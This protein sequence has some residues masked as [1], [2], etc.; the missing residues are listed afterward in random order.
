MQKARTGAA[1]EHRVRTI[2]QQKHLLQLVQCP[3]D[4]TRAGE[5]SVIGPLVLLRAA[6][7]LDLRKGMFLGDED[8][9]KGLV[10]AQQH[11]IARLQLL[12]EV[13]FKQKRLCFRPRRQEHHRRGL[14]DHPRN[15]PRMPRGPGIVRHPRLEVPRLADVKHT[16]LRIQHPVHP[17]RAVKRLEVGLDQA[18]PGRRI[19]RRLLV[20][21]DHG[22]L[23]VILCDGCTLSAPGARAKASTI[24]VDNS[25][26]KFGSHGNFRWFRPLS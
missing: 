20:L 22:F 8:I 3:V 17:R 13:L 23:Y 14:S 15:P 5:G 10:V 24:L 16:R 1:L 2:A 19:P 11:I 25:A 7:L 6:M 21:V 12:D 4:R 26:D 9:R 18:V